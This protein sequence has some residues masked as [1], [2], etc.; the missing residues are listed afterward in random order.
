MVRVARAEALVE[1]GAAGVIHPAGDVDVDQAAACRVLH[2]GVHGAEHAAFVRGGVAVALRE[3]QAAVQEKILFLLRR[4]HERLQHVGDGGE[5]FEHAVRGLAVGLATDDAALGVGRAGV[6]ADHLQTDAVDGAEVA[7]DVRRHDGDR[8][9]DLVEVLARGMAAK[10]GVVVAGAEDPARELDVRP[11]GE[12]L[13]PGH[14]IVNGVDR[15]VRWGEQVGSDGLCAELLDV[16]M[17][18]DEP[19]H[20]RLAGEVL[21]HGACALLLECVGL[22]ANESDPAVVHDD[23]LDR[24]GLVAFHR[25]DGAAADDEVRARRGR[26]AGGLLAAG[27]E[28]EG[29]GEDGGDGRTSIHAGF[30]GR[31]ALAH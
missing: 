7:R 24:G 8:G 25:D 30:L 5:L 17:A 22:A 23:R 14:E 13:E 3:L 31:L 1:F 27:G 16:G 15:A 19:G 11:V 29:G 20:Q 4:R 28:G 26:V 18:V 12:G 6:V 2:V 9:R 10:Q 21:Q